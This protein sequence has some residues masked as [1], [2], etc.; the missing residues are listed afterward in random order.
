[1]PRAPGQVDEAK[2]DAILTA[3]VDLFSAKGPRATM[4]EIA[5]EAG[6]SK[7][8]LYNR[9]SSKTEIARALLNRRSLAI[10]APLDDD[11]SLQETLTGV[12]ERLVERALDHRSSEHM[13]ALALVARDEPDLAHAVFES[14]PDK[15]LAR[16][17]QWLE[18]Q[19]RKGLLCV[20][21]PPEAAEI[22]VGMVMGHAHF[23]LILG[24]KPFVHDANI[25]A[26]EAAARFIRAYAPSTPPAT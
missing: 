13:R 10:T 22:F 17:A 18:L 16:I 21:N 9:F 24:L 19:D 4:T 20:P 25:H 11:A 7:Q 12:A 3:A 15:S 23:R 2:S 26:A 14:G 1:M 8:T 5:R 6:V